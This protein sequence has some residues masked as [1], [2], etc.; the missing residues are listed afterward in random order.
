MDYHIINLTRNSD[1]GVTSVNFRVSK[2]SGDYEEFM[3]ISTEFTPDSSA[4][5]F[6]AYTDITKQNVIDWITN[7]LDMA[8]VETQLTADLALKTNP[9]LVGVPWPEEE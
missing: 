6:I 7:K 4:E 2:T 5:G 1:G 3:F 8:G 9:P